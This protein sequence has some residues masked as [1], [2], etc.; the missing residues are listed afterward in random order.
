[1]PHLDHL[2]LAVD[3]PE[4]VAALFETLLGARPYKQETVDG[5]GVRTHFIAAGTAKLELLESVAPD[6]PI[7]RF[8]EHR[9]E[10]MHHLAFEVD[11]IE[12]TMAHCRDHGFT[13]LS[14]AP[15]P[16]ADGKHIFFLHP[17]DTHGLLIEFCQ[18]VPTP[19]TPSFV[20]YGDGQLAVYDAGAAEAPPVLLLHGAAGCTQLE[21]APLLRRLE[22]HYRILAVDFSGHGASTDD[23]EFSAD[24]FADNARAVLDAK[25]IE[26]VDVF[27]FSMGGYMALHFAQQHPDRVRRLA[28]HGTN[29][30]WDGERVEAM[31][32]RMDAEAIQQNRPDLATDLDA[33]HTD[34]PTLF[35]RMQ[36]FVATLPAHSDDMHRIA[37]ALDHPTLVSAV[38]HDDLFPLD[39][40]LAL[41]AA[42]PNSTLAVIPGNRHALQAVNLDLLTPLLCDHLD[43]G[44][45]NAPTGPA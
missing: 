32:G 22:L 17:K 7:A 36:D 37:S 34:W 39:A 20:P 4:P 35:G 41:H 19:L 11:N 40:P 30:D 12:A 44:A 33:L 1:M 8:L 29:I 38:D 21:T 26:H 42:L 16:G 9:G 14:D 24:R 6:S 28:I 18:S 23:V 45:P 10:G 15:Q 27:G 2:G 3:A 13:P 25:G 31:Q 43:G 5:Q